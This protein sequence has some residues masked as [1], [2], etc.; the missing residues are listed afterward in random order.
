MEDRMLLPDSIPEFA[1]YDA[2]DSGTR[3]APLFVWC[4]LIRRLR[5]LFMLRGANTKPEARLALMVATAQRD[6]YARSTE[7]ML[8]ERLEAQLAAA[9]DAELQELF[10]KY[11]SEP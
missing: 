7:P 4:G 1:V 5:L 8:I 2:Y 11:L 9:D 6:T 3:K 10:A